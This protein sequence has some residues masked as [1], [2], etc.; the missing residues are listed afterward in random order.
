MTE[1]TKGYHERVT[2]LETELAKLRADFEAHKANQP[3]LIADE[4]LKQVTAALAHHTHGHA[5]HG[6]GPQLVK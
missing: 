1:T 4:V 5:E 3:G 6:H 2:E